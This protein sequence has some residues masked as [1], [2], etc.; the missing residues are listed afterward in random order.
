MAVNSS[1][2]QCVRYLNEHQSINLW[3]T[4]SFR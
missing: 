1:G 2:K 3:P 4:D